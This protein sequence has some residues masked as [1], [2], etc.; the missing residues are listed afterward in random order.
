MITNT[1]YEDAYAAQQALLLLGFD[2]N[3]IFV[4]CVQTR[5][6]TGVIR[7]NVLTVALRAGKL[8]FRIS[9]A[10]MGDS[11]KSDE[12]NLLWQKYAESIVA[13]EFSEDHLSDVFKRSRFGQT[14]TLA[15][16]H[17]SL[18]KKGFEVPGLKA[19]PSEAN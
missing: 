18:T 11:A 5:L 17:I 15:S 10:D 7:E 13:G 2:S 9:I 8:E 12:V 4:G 16:L 14:G 3:A 6:P 19:P 1:P